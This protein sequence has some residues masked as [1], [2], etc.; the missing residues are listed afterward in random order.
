LVKLL[1]GLYRPS[2]GRVTVEG[3]DL[4]SLEPERWRERISA[5]FQDLARFEFPLRETV[6]IGDLSKLDDET[7]IR[8]ALDLHGA[9]VAPVLDRADGRPDHRA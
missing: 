5:A 4:E 6:G 1:A 9:R 3:V 2:S 8:N 7:E